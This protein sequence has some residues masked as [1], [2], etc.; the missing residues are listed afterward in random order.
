MHG[1]SIHGWGSAPIP[2]PTLLVVDGFD[3]AS[4]RFL[5]RVNPRFGVPSQGAAAITS[6]FRVSL[7]V[8]FTLNGNVQHAQ[9]AYWLRS[10]KGRPGQRPPSDT[11]LSRMIAQGV[12]PASPYTWI[13]VNSDSLL[14]SDEQLRSVIDARTRFSTAVDSV[15]RALA[16]DLAARPDKYDPDVVQKR[17]DSANTAV[18][19]DLTRRQG[20]ILSRILTPIQLRLLP[21]SIA[22]AVGSLTPP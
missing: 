9:I 14:L 11:I 5:Y 12:A 7:D 3:P 6:P 19:T 20:A 16:D 10:P 1:A 15:W 4:K 17:I 8:S 22:R 13:I 21:A 18:Y 2:D